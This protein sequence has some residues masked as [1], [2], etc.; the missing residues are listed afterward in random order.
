MKAIDFLRQKK[1]HSLVLQNAI[2]E[3]RLNKVIKVKWRELFGE[4]NK[5]P[6]TSKSDF[7]LYIPTN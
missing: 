3:V 6:I 4:G 7:K 1:V 2:S 5:K